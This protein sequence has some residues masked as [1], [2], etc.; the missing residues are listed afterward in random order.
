MPAACAPNMRSQLSSTL[1]NT[2]WASAIELPMTCSTSA[3]AVWWASASC[4]SLNRRTFSIA[5]TAWS[6]KVCS[7]WNGEAGNETN[8]P[9]A[10]AA[11]GRSTAA[12]WIMRGI[13][14]GQLEL[15]RPAGVACR[16]N[17]QA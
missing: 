8:S 14:E 2:G 10:S 12:G 6:A 13:P 9:S 4:V 16:A 7:S 3:L 17:R 5:I 1:S 11:D 15:R